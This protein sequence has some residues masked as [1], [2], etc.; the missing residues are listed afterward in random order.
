MTQVHVRQTEHRDI[1]EV[2][3]LM[4]EYVVGD[5]SRQHTGATILRQDGRSG[6]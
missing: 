1:D 4:Y 2:E 3:A 5:G 6:G